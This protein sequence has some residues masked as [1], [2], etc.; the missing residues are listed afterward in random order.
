MASPLSDRMNYPTL[1]HSAQSLHLL[2]AAVCVC[3]WPD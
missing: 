1:L 2:Q 3:Q